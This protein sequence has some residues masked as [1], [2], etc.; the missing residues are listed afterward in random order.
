MLYEFELKISNS[1]KWINTK[2]ESDEIWSPDLSQSLKDFLNINLVHSSTT[3]YSSML[4][5]QELKVKTL[6]DAKEMEKARFLPRVGLF[7]QN[8][9]YSGDRNTA[10]A[11]AYGL[12]I[13]WDIFNSD[14]F[15][16]VGE[17]NAK[18]MAALAKLQAGKQEEKIMLQQLMETKTTLEKSLILLEGTDTLLKEQTQ[19]AMK[20]FR[21]GMLSALQL[22]EVINRRVDLLEKKNIVEAQYLDVYSRLYQL[23]N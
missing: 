3:S 4:L 20:L 1:K 17:A 15:G 22:A 5:S 11:Q 14:S 13:M 7:A 18:S 8:N 19:N 23:N 12:Y 6:E 9:I 16:R 21:S 10:N 2:T